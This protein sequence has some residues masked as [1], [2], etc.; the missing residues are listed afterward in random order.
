MSEGKKP[1]P[2]ARRVK[3][4]ERPPMVLTE[5][6]QA[7][8]VTVNQF[9]VIRGQ[10]LERL[11]FSSRSTAQYRLQRLF[12]HEYLD[13]HFQSVV[14]GGPASSPILYSLGKRGAE[15]LIRQHGLL[16]T[17]IRRFPK[18]IPAHTL[19]HL[20]EV[21]EVRVAVSLACQT[22]GYLLDTWLDESVFR[23]QPDYVF[24]RDG[25]GREQKKPVYPDGYFALT[26]P[27]GTAHFFLESDRG[28]EARSAFKPQIAVYEAY[29]RGGG[30]Q[31]RF[32]TRS[33]RILIVCPGRERLKNLKL[34]TQE[35]GGDRK[36]WF[37]TFDQISPETILT[38]PIWERLESE[39][40][41]ALIG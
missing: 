30:Y 19:D 13:R 11:F 28:T 12:Q 20:L 40:K 9:Q 41:Q 8:L 33:L 27:A 34:V 2:R 16:D 4:D 32:N 24:L 17:D 25:R 10:Q 6:D 3:P 22:Q 38:A 37:T 36:Y 29:T 15:L 39:E 14:E 26:A 7:L 23:A 18:S 5:R 1:L 35:A 21:N 31:A